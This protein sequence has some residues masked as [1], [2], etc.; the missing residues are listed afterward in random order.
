MPSSGE[1]FCKVVKITPPDGRS[2]S[3]RRCSR[4]S[5]CCGVWRNR[6]LHM[7]NVPN[8]WSSRSLRSVSTTSVGFC[9]AGCLMIW[10]A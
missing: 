2:S 8:N 4:S 10:P 7:L 5:A 6:S 1:N 9:I 3:L